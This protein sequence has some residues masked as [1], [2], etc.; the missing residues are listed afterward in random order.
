MGDE[1]EGEKMV[2]I[3][4][5]LSKKERKVGSF[6]ERIQGCFFLELSR[7]AKFKSKLGNAQVKGGSECQ[8]F[9]AAAK[10]IS[11]GYGRK[12]KA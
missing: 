7:N 11:F 10:E 3:S 12:D 1:E 4:K 9:E 6:A 2:K 5:N 8:I